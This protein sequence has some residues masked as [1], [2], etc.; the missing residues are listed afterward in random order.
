[1]SKSIKPDDYFR[2]GPIEMARFGR[3]TVI[4]SNLKK[5]E[6]ERYQNTLVSKLPEIKIAIDALVSDVA[7]RVRKYQPL[8]LLQRG[9][10]EMLIFNTN[11]D[12]KYVQSVLTLEYI[13][14]LIAANDKD[15]REKEELTDQ[16]WAVLSDSI[17]KLY[18]MISS[19]YLHSESARQQK[20][21]GVSL[22][23]A[24]LN[25]MA[26]VHWI[27]VRGVRYSVHEV[28]HLK[29]LILCHSDAL[30]KTF[31][32]TADF[33]I[34]EISKIFHSL[35]YGFYEAGRQLN[36]IYEGYSKELEQR[37]IESDPPNEIKDYLGEYLERNELAGRFREA[38]RKYHGVDLFDLGKIT[39]LP[40]SFLDL[41]AWKPGEDEEFLADGEFKGWPLRISPVSRRPFLKIVGR[42]YCFSLS[43]LFDHFYRTIQRTVI[44]QS[45]D[46]KVLWMNRQNENT[47][48]LPFA[49]LRRL[50][51]GCLE[52]SQLYY[53]WYPRKNISKKHWCETD[54]FVL[55]GD[56]LLIIE[57]KAGAFTYT[58]PANDFEAYIKSI[59]N[60]LLR[61]SDQGARFLDYIN[62]SETVNLYDKDK[63]QVGKLE[64]KRIRKVTICALTI[65]PFTEITSQIQHL[66]GIGIDIGTTP[67]WSISLDDLRVCSEIFLNP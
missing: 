55:F 12:G 60:L 62:S 47:E 46:Q 5:K 39:I 38:M 15:C 36:D 23:K 7:E 14:N 8:E 45:P 41:L 37:K 9:F 52:K 43:A 49:Y 44:Q 64:R 11:T 30:E 54:G 58:S 3:E 22:E 31:G 57:V 32:I 66:K 33:L 56:H 61:P 48:L 65:D 2:G 27:T 67:T 6:F 25:F 4:Q 16:G 1:M 53:K 21:E 28:P 59:E 18:G 35:T 29:D 10:R 19:E 42:F 17:S 26:Q 63:K 24:M 34:T 51:P 13:Q 20:N 50:L 40:N